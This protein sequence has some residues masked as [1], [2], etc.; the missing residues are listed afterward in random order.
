MPVVTAVLVV[1]ALLVGAGIGVAVIAFR[2]GTKLGAARR[3]RQQLL[4]EARREAE[5][6]RRETQIEAREQSVR[7]RADL[8]EELKERR[9]EVLRAEERQRGREHELDAKLTEVSRREQGLADRETHTK[10]LQEQLK[11][12]KD[13]ELKELERISGMTVGEAKAHV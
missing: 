3:V 13:S 10:Q 4:A 12:A 7:L 2:S 11:A 8:E 5:A 6:L 1:L 9:A